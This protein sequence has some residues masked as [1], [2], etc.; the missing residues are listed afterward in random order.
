[1]SIQMHCRIMHSGCTKRNVKLKKAVYYYV[2]QSVNQ[3]QQL[4]KLNCA[5][6]INSEYIFLHMYVNVYRTKYWAWVISVIYSH[7]LQWFQQT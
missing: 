3:Q 6:K 5:A 1:M 7:I 4:E 2:S